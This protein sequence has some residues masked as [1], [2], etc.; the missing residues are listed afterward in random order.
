MPLNSNR[1][2][3]MAGYHSSVNILN[4]Y[5]VLSSHCF[6]FLIFCLHFKWHT[7]GV[8]ATPWDSFCSFFPVIIE[9]VELKLKSKYPLTEYAVNTSF[10]CIILRLFRSVMSFQIAPLWLCDHII[11]VLYPKF[12][13]CLVLPL[14]FLL[15]LFVAISSGTLMVW[16]ATTWHFFS[17]LYCY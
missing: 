7:Y 12:V 4:P 17:A 2:T 14:F 8:L 16:L 13:Y 6:P 15:S 3:L 9:L 1:I 5:I 11:G 10:C